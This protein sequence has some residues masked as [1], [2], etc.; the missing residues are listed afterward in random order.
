MLRHVLLRASGGLMGSA[1]L[2]FLGANMD[3]SDPA[4]FKPLARR[5]VRGVARR[6]VRRQISSPRCGP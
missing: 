4:G 5:S 6:A 1:E 3:V 2:T